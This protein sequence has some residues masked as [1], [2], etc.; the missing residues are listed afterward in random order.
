VSGTTLGAWHTTL[1]AWHRLPTHQPSRAAPTHQP[2]RASGRFQ[3][4]AASTA[5]S[6]GRSR[7]A[8]R[9]TGG[10]CHSP[11]SRQALSA[12]LSAFLNSPFNEKHANTP[13]FAIFLATHL[14]INQ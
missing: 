3:A 8:A 4:N 5:R 7:R 2:S 6:T 10:L 1:G 13:V 14:A 11:H 9:S 12:L